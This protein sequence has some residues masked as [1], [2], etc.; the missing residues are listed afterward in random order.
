MIDLKQIVAAVLTLGMFAMLINMINNGPFL[1]TDQLS[2]QGTYV[3]EADLRRSSKASNRTDS[4]LKELWGRP[5]PVLQPCWDKHIT[6]LKGKTWGYIGVTLSNGAHYHRVQIADAVVIAKYLGAT[7][8][9]PTIKDGYKEPNGQFEKIYDIN[10]FII[11]LQN[12]VRVVGRLPDDMTSA[13][14]ELIHVPYKVTLDYI[15]KH[16]RPIFNQKPVIFLDSFP[17]SV[18]S[19]ENEGEDA[20]LDAVRCLVMYK[21][22]RFHSQLIKLGGRILNRMREAGDM[23]DGRFIAVDLRVGVLQRKGC[24]SNISESN[25]LKSK[26]VNPLE[27]GQF[28]KELGFPTNTAIYLTQSRWDPTLDPLREL[29]PNIYTKE[30]SMPFNE[31]RQILYTGKTQFEK[32]LD[33]YIC[34]QSDIFIPVIPGMFYSVVAGERIALGKTQILV[35]NLKHNSASKLK[36][37]DSLSRY[38]TKKD[39]SVYSCFC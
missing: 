24:N 20:G 1:D 39:H 5:G 37:A 7:L 17:Q 13:S 15:D 9:L 10:N 25:K 23:S 29:F 14:P 16:I 27:F 4:R 35:P 31:E 19:K 36:L 3:K 32:A 30:Y 38:M 8:L 18:N 11:S 22:L 33:F 2:S 12:I 26:C 6:N 34:S 28:L 21:A